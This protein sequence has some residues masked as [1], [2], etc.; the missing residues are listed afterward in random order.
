MAR[1]IAVIT[2]L[3]VLM[4][5]EVKADSASD[6]R[7]AKKFSPILILT[8]DNTGNYGKISVIKPEPVNIMRVKSADSLQIAVYTS[9]GSK[10]AG[11]FRWGSLNNA[12]WNPPAFSGVNFSQ[13]RYAFLDNKYTGKPLLKGKRRAYGIYRVDSYFNY[14]GNGK[15]SW[16]DTY[17]GKGNKANNE[18]MGNKFPNTAYVHIDTATISNYRGKFG[19]T[20]GVATVLRYKYFYP[21]NDWWNNH[22]GDWQGIDVVVSSQNPDTAEFLGV[23]FKFHKAWLT[24]YKDYGTHPGITGNY[25]FNPQQD[26]KLIGTHPV[27]YIGAGSHAAYPIGGKIDL[28]DASEVRIVSEGAQDAVVGDALVG[29]KEYMS[30][31]GLVLST[32]AD[33]SRRDLW[34]SYHLELLPNPDP[35]NTNNMGL[36][37]SLSWLGAQIRWGTPQV[38]GLPKTEKK[39][40]YGPYAGKTK[41][42]W[43]KLKLDAVGSI[44]VGEILGDPFYHSDLEQITYHH[45]AIIGN[46]T[47]SD[48]VSLTGDVV[49]FPGAT[50]T[51]KPNT[52]VEFKPGKDRHKFTPESPSAPGSDDFTEIFVYGTLTAEGKSDSLITFQSD[53]TYQGNYAW[54]GIRKKDGATV[55]LNDHTRILDAPPLKVAFKKASYEVDLSNGTGE[56]ADSVAVTVEVIRTPY[57]RTVTIPITVTALDAESGDYRVSGLTSGALNF[58]VAHGTQSFTVTGLPDSDFDNDRVTLGFGTL[59]DGVVAGEQATATV[60]ILD[61]GTTPAAPDT[62][63]TDPYTGNV[64][65]KWDS[66]EATP[67]VTGYE[68]EYQSRPGVGGT[69]PW[70]AWTA[71]ATPA[72]GDTSYTH[73]GLSYP[74]KYRYRLRATNA[75]GAGAWSGALP[76]YGVAPYPVGLQAKVVQVYLNPNVG[77][78]VVLDCPFSEPELCGHLA[79]L[80]LSALGRIDFQFDDG[81]W[82]PGG[83]LGARGAS[84]AKGASGATQLT[85]VIPLEGLDQTRAHKFEVRFVT[86]DG[87]ASAASEPVRLIPLRASAADGAVRLS[88]DA[89][90]DTTITGWQYRFRPERRRWGAWQA[91]SGSGA[92]TT[93]Q[94]VGSLSNGA[95]YQFQVRAAYSEG[96]RAASF[97]ASA[98]PAGAPW[99]PDSLT[100][101]AG[102]AQVR[103]SWAAADSN[104]A[105][106]TGYSLRDSLAGGSWSDWTAVPGGGT[107]RDTTRSKLSNG[108]LYTFEVRAQNRVGH[109]D[110]SR[111][112]VTPQARTLAGPDSISY[113][114]NGTDTVA[115]YR[116]TPGGG[117]WTWSRAGA[118]SSAFSGGDTLRF[119]RAPNFEVPTDSDSNNVYTLQVQATPAAPGLSPLSKA[120]VV[121]VTNVNEPGAISFSPSRPK[122]NQPITATLSD[123]DT[124]A[125]VRHWRWLPYIEGG[126]GIGGEEAEET[127]TAAATICPGMVSCTYTPG[128]F[129]RYLPLEVTVFYR[130]RLA[131]GQQQVRV[132]TAPVGG[133]NRAPT[134]SGVSD[135]TFVEND[136]AAVALYRGADADGDALRWSLT[137]A[138]SSAFRWQGSGLTRALRFAAAPDYEAKSTYRVTAGVSDGAVAATQAVTVRVTNVDEAPVLSGPADTTV[139]EHGSGT[140]ALYRAVDPEGE[141]VTW[142]LSGADRDTLALSGGGQLSFKRAPDYERPAD[143]DSDNVYAVRVR[144]FDGPLGDSLAVTV[145]VSNV[146]EAG[147]V[148]LSSSSPQAGAALSAT[149]SDPDSVWAST[150]GWQWQRLSSRSAAGTPI[151]SATSASYTPQ[152]ADV[153]RWLVAKASYR[154]GHGAGKSAADTTAAA[155]AGRPGAPKSLAASAGDKQVAL[156]WTAADSNGAWVTGYSLRDSLAGGSWSSWTVVPGGG[157]ARK[158]TVTGLTNDTLYTFEVRAKNRV[159][160]G[161]SSRVS[162]RPQAVP[163]APDTLIASAGNRRVALSWTYSSSVPVTRWQERHKAGSRAWGSWTDIANST[164][165]TRKDTVTGLTNDTLYTFEVRGVNGKGAG[166]A[167][168]PAT[169][170]PWEDIPPVLSGSA[171]NRQVALSWTYTGKAP[172]SSWQYRR[173]SALGDFSGQ[174]QQTSTRIW[175]PWTNIPGSNGST[176]KDTVTGL[177]NGSKYG[178]EVRGLHGSIKR[179]ASNKVIVTPR[180]APPP[181]AGPPAATLSASAGNAQ[182]ALSWTY[183]STSKVTGWQQRHK[184]GSKTWGSW[185]GVAGS[186]GSTRKDTVTGLTN[187]TLY[188]FEVRG[189]NGQIKGTASNQVSATPKAPPPTGPPAATLSASAGNAQVALSWTYSSTSKVTGWQQRHKAGSKTWGSWTGVAGS[190]GSTRKDTVTGLTNDTLYTFEVR[191]VNGQIKGTASNPA[192]AT[193]K[194]PPPT[195]PDRPDKLTASAGNRQVTLNWTYSSTVTVTGWQYR[196]ESALGDFSAGQKTSTRIWGP[197]TPISGAATRSHTVTGLTNGSEYGFEVRGVNG[198]VKGTTSNKVTATP[199]AP[200]PP[201]PPAPTLSAS[202][203]NGR[204]TLSWA[205]SS[206]VTVTGWQYRRES[207]FEDLSGGQK[208]TTRV[209]GPWK[210]ISGAATRS[211]TVTGL[212][213]GSEYGFE[214]RGVNGKTEGTASNKVTATPKAPATVPGSPGSLS[215]AAGNKQV[216]LSWSA[217]ASNG[218]AIQR[219]EYRRGSGSWT[220]VSG[221]G[222]ARSQTVTG[223][224][225]GTSYTFSVRAVNGVGA[226]TAA[227]AS[228]TPAGR[229]GTPGSLSASAGNKQVTLSWSAAAPNGSAIQRY[230][231]RRGSGSWTTVSGGGS[232]RSQTVTGLTNGTSYT[233]SVRAVNGV[234]AGTAASASATPAGRPGSPGGLSASAGNR[235]VT[236]SWSAAASNG[237]AIQRYEYRRGLLGSWTTVSG[238]GSAR[239]QTVTGLT[240]GTTYLFYVRA[241]N[242]KGAGSAASASAKPA[243]VPGSPGSLSAAAGFG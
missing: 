181:P 20:N 208:T 47:W 28:F 124:V 104:G 238:G 120:V 203:G 97:T 9:L 31:T 142:S 125:S 63:T 86:P 78:E 18:Y 62:L 66:L 108:T 72:A 107:A 50:L 110:S 25:V 101:T 42:G 51:I 243:G 40:P 57:L 136:T 60:T 147:T 90:S 185:T 196:R 100:A 1:M 148:S 180:A 150:V 87:Q 160:T 137:G 144:A 17:F 64:T 14:P 173:E 65:V 193:P 239:S 237:S 154:D 213:N 190:T 198:K 33:N 27:A 231:Y 159:G 128:L 67:A 79:Q 210:S 215:A 172:V 233:F 39:S 36:P 149:L 53:S 194:A 132:V 119:A 211:H 88:W 114:E 134:L 232:A 48:T 22:E 192:T 145:R 52:V 186:T 217:A 56:V 189:V 29:D 184:A 7:L 163:P 219:Y 83:A 177:T 69:P 58:A 207:D 169:A 129:F 235:Q 202:A 44:T 141:A 30:H 164:G 135:T 113:A 204:V 34:E 15:K 138:D 188:T 133:P 166:T 41:R 118:D 80:D 242:G 59:P 240:N 2:L 175:G 89:L 94:R 122:V 12:N 176:R 73:R 3:S 75:R 76:P 123:A 49:I 236:L 103:L 71:L 182:V 220:T 205:Y 92:S 139:V 82:R 68:L 153:G 152:G 91:T 191:G 223:L 106:V 95:D 165:S 197:W 131:S 117:S 234:G 5:D 221:G 157:A 225:N 96:T 16:D 126:I 85:A 218:S 214:V 229:P 4:V 74:T 151:G 228:A 146:E 98:K 21:Y 201:A 6:L 46:E 168:N 55:N 179:T 171:G 178:F 216:A 200:P 212:T 81:G 93:T 99:A 105:W 102:N 23:E 77:L 54:A 8:E 19:L 227:S 32:L 112:S 167:S 162:A 187:D 206:T 109:G 174:G 70:E 143:A 140:V 195:G 61:H 10:V 45:W 84:G 130:D 121:T 224:T 209:W 230:E 183:S 156:R 158:D 13:N 170:T 26:I 127:A 35:T 116:V 24:Y 241:V 199:Q 111:V 155:V 11:F 115:V 38:D 226:G 222:S 43:G 37:D 161:D